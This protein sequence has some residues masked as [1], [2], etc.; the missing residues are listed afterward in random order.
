MILGNSNTSIKKKIIFPVALIYLVLIIFFFISLYWIENQKQE[1]IAK[2]YLHNLEQSFLRK[3]DDKAVQQAIQIHILEQNECVQ[4][5]LDSL[6]R[7]QLSSC[8][9][10]LYYLL[11]D[12]FLVSELNIADAAGRYFFRYDQ[13]DNYGD[14]PQGFSITRAINTN[15]LSY[16]LTVSSLESLRMVV[17]RGILTPFGNRFFIEIKTQVKD[18]LNSMEIAEDITL[19]VMLEKKYLYG[20]NK[21][22]T[23]SNQINPYDYIYTYGEDNNFIET[24]I[25]RF[26]T[27][28]DE[29]EVGLISRFNFKDSF[30]TM[31]K[32]SLLDEGGRYFGHLVFIKDQTEDVH[33]LQNSF[34]QVAIIIVFITFIIYFITNHYLSLIDSQLNGSYMALTNEID[35]RKSAEKKINEQQQFLQSIINGIDD[36]VMVITADYQVELMNN[37]A[38]ASMDPKFV[39]DPEPPRCYELAHHRHHPC[40]GENH[41][42]PLRNVLES[43]GTNKVIH[44]HPLSDGGER[45]FELVATPLFDSQGKAFAIIE[46]GRDITEHMN[47]QEE[48]R[49]QKNILTHQATHDA[50]TKLPNR[51]LFI[52]RLEQSIKKAKRY[53]SQVAVLFIDLDR[54][55][56]IN[57]SL[58]HSY[59]DKVLIQV[60]ERLQA[61]V[62]GFDTISRLGGDEFTLILEYVRVEDVHQI[63]KKLLSRLQEKLSINNQELYITSSIGISIYPRDGDTTEILLK[64]ADAAMYKAKE[65]GK[66]NYHFYTSDMS[67]KAY[68]RILMETN[69]RHAIQ[70][71]ELIVFYQPQID[72][73]SEKLVGMEALVRW[74]LPD[75]KMIPPNHFIPL[76]VETGLINQLDEWVLEQAC[77]D[78]VKW[79]H[80]NYHP[81]RIAINI[82]A[83]ELY[84]KNFIQRLKKILDKTKCWPEWVELEITEDYL[85]TDPDASADILLQIKNMGIQLAIDDFGTGYSSLSYLKKLPIHKLKIDQSFIR[86]ITGDSDDSSITCTIISLTKNMNL[87]VIAEGV[88]TAEQQE[89]LL[90]HGCEK[91][92]GY[93]Y[94]KPMPAKEIEDLLKQA[95]I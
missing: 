59:G 60:A 54:F 3:I 15:R 24:I 5:A 91:V 8:I 92:Q 11:E 82:S 75:G 67:E 35:E 65:N 90:Q 83:K 53:K 86:D 48:L 21:T 9:D 28:D 31:G 89:F 80:E 13:P 40:D 46:A 50:L 29:E 64:N 63:A 44:N 70:N 39:T 66:N 72:S 30:Y 81:G 87:D 36:S 45:I 69:L 26:G 38:R 14:V 34:I 32:L 25:E 33:A 23:E 71:N 68:D 73:R 52:D 19:V 62:R 10:S 43:G 41:P 61:S 16:G 74:L 12:T 2:N 56:E 93:L 22:N 51:V 4:K 88:E 95:V 18:V 94:H 55:K 27:H 58:G 1:E 6:D 49:Q 77:K 57:D 42:C 84:Q 79:R 37:T 78:Q 20:T 17:A 7:I 85:M 47:I 76:A